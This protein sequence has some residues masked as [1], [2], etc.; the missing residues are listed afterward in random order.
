MSRLLE[1]IA[2]RR[3]ATASSRLGPRSQ[4]V[5][6]WAPAQPANGSAAAEE[7]APAPEPVPEPAP[8]P[9]LEPAPLA[10]DAHGGDGWSTNV[11]QDAQNVDQPLE[12]ALIKPESEPEDDHADDWIEDEDEWLEP[13]PL[14]EPDEQT[15]ETEPELE[16]EVEEEVLYETP[17]LPPRESPPARPRPSRTPRPVPPE[18]L[19]FAERGQMRRR[20]RYL[21]RLR[22]VQLRD[23]G[24][25]VLELNRYGRDRPDLVAAKVRAAAGTDDELRALERAIDGHASLRELREAG[26]GGACMECGAVHGSGDRFCASC[27]A[28]LDQDLDPD[29]GPDE[30]P[31]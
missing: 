29:D 5:S 4:P 19:G 2:R 28:A 12:S 1:S 18:Q 17:P 20:A 9:A 31:R 15:S 27:G 11:A 10:E 7:L 30:S 3:R 25:F 13:P 6:G 24:G 21:R 22:E 26:I 8:D 23:L 16:A 14:S